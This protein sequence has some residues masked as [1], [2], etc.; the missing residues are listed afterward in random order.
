MT[1]LVHSAAAPGLSVD[2]DPREVEATV[3][4]LRQL[5]S[6]DVPP[7]LDNLA[8]RLRE[9]AAGVAIVGLVNR[10]KSTLFNQLVGRDIAHTAATPETAVP[11]VARSGSPQQYA[12]LEDGQRV[13]LSG[14]LRREGATLSGL[15]NV[16]YASYTGR[17]RLPA[18]I[19]LIDTPGLNEAAGSE[20]AFGQRLREWRET[21]GGAALLVLSAPP[22]LASSDL[23][24]LDA[25]ARFF[26][27]RLAIVLKAT[28]DD[29]TSEDLSEVAADIA[30]TT[31][32]RV[33]VVPHSA[34][35]AGWGEDERWLLLE[36]QLEALAAQAD[37]GL[38]ADRT[39]YEQCVHAAVCWIGGTRGSAALDILESVRQRS[40]HHTDSRLLSA[41]ALGCSRL[42]AQLETDELAATTERERHA[43][44][45]LRGATQHAEAERRRIDDAEAV[46]AIAALVRGMNIAKSYQP[47]GLADKVFGT[48]RKERWE[49]CRPALDVVCR[50]AA[51][52]H[53]GAQ[54]EL[55]RLLASSEGHSFGVDGA[56][57]ASHLH[58]VDKMKR[59]ASHLPHVD[60]SRAPQ[61][62]GKHGHML[63]AVLIVKYQDRIQERDAIAAADRLRDRLSR[64]DV[65]RALEPEGVAAV[66]ALTDRGWVAR[67]DDLNRRCQAVVYGYVPHSVATWREMHTQ[68]KKAGDACPGSVQHRFSPLARWVTQLRDDEREW[69]AARHA[70]ACTAAEERAST[71]NRRRE[72]R[73]IS[74]YF[75]WGLACLMLA[76]G[77]AMKVAS[78]LVWGSSFVMW[79]STRG[80]EPRHPAAFMR[81]PV[82]QQAPDVV[83]RPHFGLAPPP[84]PP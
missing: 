84:P 50:S 56:E 14:A 42:R 46:Q 62:T 72:L 9:G 66:K 5:P 32:R 21:F 29:V 22:G 82:A 58:S 28:S 73:S 23:Q 44:E 40:D 17:L 18:G 3:A 48:G 37:T 70:Q 11:Q 71:L 30:D 24:V 41:L 83:L 64:P 34:P 12:R 33:L 52:G 51:D 47:V 77:D 20:E 81:P 45:R 8:Q 43:A 63:D 67:I 27:E 15:H 31:G 39:R 55:L 79:L 75:L 65:A 16:V 76:G 1:V 74:S 38:D 59:A 10:G 35:T 49:A 2:L 25:V 13:E 36:R 57:L 61:V 54:E 19:T 6:V 26:D 68:L 4:S 80:A 7:G 78:V 60:P 53:G 69:H